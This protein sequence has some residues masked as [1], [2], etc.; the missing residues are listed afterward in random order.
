MRRYLGS[1]LNGESARQFVMMV[2]IGVVNTVVDFGL[3]NVLYR[4]G[5]NAYVSVTVAFVIATA[6]S[7]LLNRRFTFGLSARGMSAREGITFMFVNLAALLVT[8]AAVWAA[9]RWFGPLDQTRLNIAK[10]V[11]TAVILIPKFA[12]YRDLVFK[13]ALRER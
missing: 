7:Y 13:R 1:F 10:L 9:E 12:G 4:L 11:A 3:V 8:Y 5:W 2:V 6:V